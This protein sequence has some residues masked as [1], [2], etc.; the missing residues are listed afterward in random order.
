MNETLVSILYLL[1]VIVVM[2]ISAFGMRYSWFRL[3]TRGAKSLFMLLFLLF[4]FT[5]MFFMSLFTRSNEGM[6]NIM[7]IVH[8]IILMIPFPWTAMVYEMANRDMKDIWHFMVP[9]TILNV[10]G[11]LHLVSPLENMG[12]PMSY[13][14]CNL[15][16]VI[17]RCQIDHS[18]FYYVLM[19]VLLFEILGANG[20]LIYYFLQPKQVAQRAKYMLLVIAMTVGSI[21]LFLI[22]VVVTL[23]GGLDPLPLGIGIQATLLFHAIFNKDLISLTSGGSTRSVQSVDDVY[24]V[25]D[26]DHFIQ[27]V[28]LSTLQIFDMEL[29]DILNVQMEHAFV[30]YPEII[31]IF[32]KTR[33]SETIDLP[34]GTDLHTFEPVL[35]EE[36][37]P[38]TRLVVGHRL[39]MRDI[40][41]TSEP[42]SRNEN[43]ITLDPLTNQFD[44]NSFFFLGEKVFRTNRRTQQAFAIV[45]INIDDF[46][47]VN[48][49]FSHLVGD[50]VMLEL[51]E[52]INSVIRQS[53]VFSRF[54]GDNLALILPKADE[55]SSYQICARIKDMIAEHKFSFRNQEFQVTVSMGY[56]IYNSFDDDS[57]TLEQMLTFASK[58]L[59][60]SQA[61]G[62]NRLTFLPLTVE[63]RSELILQ[64]Q[65]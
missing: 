29:N 37:D 40:T 14:A 1:S 50:Q 15:L 55:F 54:E 42:R 6:R 24:L 51:V 52:I 21:S 18:I 13:S 58:A 22:G 27:D 4:A 7:L 57:W 20:Y 48:Q 59:E 44:R 53:D 2:G 45:A 16:G 33:K 39:V 35:S 49:R 34:I 17:N 61:L 43:Q 10:G 5:F 31:N 28:N 64:E 30:D 9:W 46:S 63:G 56:T 36:V 12:E 25:V 23:P 62:R 65:G 32:N 47:T 3:N 26:P 38:L 11:F 41:N 19:G 60:Q 8:A